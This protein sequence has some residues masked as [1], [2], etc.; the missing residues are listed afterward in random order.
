MYADSKWFPALDSQNVVG[1]VQEAEKEHP[2]KSRE[3]G[4]SVK[5]W[6]PIMA[7]KVLGGTSVDVS[8]QEIK[9][10]NQIAVTSRFPGAWERYQELKGE[11]PQTEIVAPVAGTPIENAN[12]LHRDRL[13]YLK[14]AGF[15]TVEQLAAMSDA[16]MQSLGR[17][18]REWRKKAVQHLQKA[19]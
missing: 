16:Q 5:I 15:S 3:V 9:P 11:K 19:S 17:G 2:G 1:Q 14:H 8:T 4:R 12:F 13:E 18:A 6:V 10:H 7:A